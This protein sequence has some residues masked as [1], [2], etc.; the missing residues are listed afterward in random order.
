[1]AYE[2]N[3]VGIHAKIFVKRTLEFDGELKSKKIETTV[4]RIIY[5]DGIPQDLGYI[6]RTNPDEMFKYEIDFAVNKKKLGDMINRCIKIHG[7]ADSAEML[8]NIKAKGF[9]Y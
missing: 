3:A 6:D 5:N 9:K 1:M 4:G 7:L 8:D 2:N